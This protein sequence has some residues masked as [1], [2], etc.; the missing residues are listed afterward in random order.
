MSD[1]QGWEV[2]QEDWV[3]RTPWDNSKA[4]PESISK[5]SPRLVSK[6]R[7]PDPFWGEPEELLTVPRRVEALA[8]TIINRRRFS[9]EKSPPTFGISVGKNINVKIASFWTLLE[10]HYVGKVRNGK[11][12]RD[13]PL[14]FLSLIR[15]SQ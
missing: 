6:K 14:Q 1:H 9:R 3:G 4:L 12:F 7:G 13:L 5:R 11:Q 10:L 2:G 15:R 8:R